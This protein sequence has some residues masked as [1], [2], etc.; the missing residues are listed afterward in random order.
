MIRTQR[1]SLP[2]L[3]LLLTVLACNSTPDVGT[4]SSG[5]PTSV[6]PAKLE[7]PVELLEPK[8]G[9]VKAAVVD[10]MLSAAA[11]NHRVVVY[12]GASWCEPCERFRAAAKAGKLDGEFAGLSL[13][14]FDIDQDRERLSAAGYKSKY[15]PLLVLPKAD[16]AASPHHMEGGTKGDGAVAQMAPR[17][18]ELLSH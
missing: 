16:G 18:K 3:G 7:G 17:L 10:A 2:W 15:I 5:G 13:L 11:R 14:V 9:D 4:S 1:S 8:A 12:V 6:K